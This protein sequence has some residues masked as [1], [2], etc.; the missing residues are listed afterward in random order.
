M[1]LKVITAGCSF[2]KDLYQKTWSDYLEYSLP[3]SE[4]TNIGARG[5]GIDFLTIR[6]INQCSAEKP[7]L[8]VAL[9][10]SVDRFDWYLDRSHPLLPEARKIASWQNGQNPDLVD[11]DGT[12][13]GTRGYSLTG[14]EIRGHKK[15]WYKYY[16]N[17]DA[18]LVNYWSKILLLQNYFENNSIDYCFSLAYD[19]DQLIEQ[20]ANY[21]SN[22][23]DLSWLYDK[24]N[25]KNF[26]MM[27]ETRGFLSFCQ[28]RHFDIVRNHPV[29]LAH[30]SW[31][32]DILMPTINRI[33][34]RNNQSLDSNE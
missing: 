4:I 13:S 22:V 19:I 7:N 26:A 23:Q 33:V 12:L 17:K 25:W 32:N 5:A 31:T 14:G 34:G 9:F 2:T 20:P 15:Y 24:I 28:S 10:P 21:R 18:V 30:E 11:I 27:D 16:Y 29:T 1:P 8:V 3:R 6:L